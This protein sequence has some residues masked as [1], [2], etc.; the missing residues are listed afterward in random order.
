MKVDNQSKQVTSSDVPPKTSNTT[1]CQTAQIPDSTLE[2]NQGI[3][4][5]A[6][7]ISLAYLSPILGEMTL[8]LED[9]G[10]KAK[11][12]EEKDGGKCGSGRAPTC[13]YPGI[14]KIIFEYQIIPS[15]F[16]VELLNDNGTALKVLYFG[17]PPAKRRK[18]LAQR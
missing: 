2:I 12:D 18:Y 6:E 11:I 14:A 16:K 4:T 10:V 7:L 3:V 5:A 15:M 8:T 1:I 9:T 17:Q 13:P